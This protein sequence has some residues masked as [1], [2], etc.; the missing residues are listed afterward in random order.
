MKRFLVASLAVVAFL[1]V[2]APPASAQAPAPKVTINGLIDT[3]TTGV[4][5]GIDGNFA[6]TDDVGWWARN[7]GVFTITGEVGK[8][9]G[10]L[11]LEIDLGWGQTGS[12]ESIVSNSGQ[13]ITASSGAFGSTQNGFHQGAFDL[14]NDVG[15]VIE[16]KNLYVEFPAPIPIPTTVR[17][18]GQPF[19]VTMKP[20]VLATTDYPGVWASMELAPFAKLNLTFAQAEEQVVGMR[21]NNAFF[22]GDD[23]FTTLSLDLIPVKGITIRPFASYY[24]IQGNSHA[25]SRCRVQCAGLPSNG[26]MVAI[27]QFTGAVT[28]GA[29][30]GNYRTAST[31]E[32]WYF[33]IDAQ[34]NFGP[35]YFDPTIIYMTSN[36]DVYRGTGDATLNGGLTQGA[37]TR[38]NQD[39]NSWLIDL[40]AG[41]RAGPL[42]IEGF[43]MWT[44]GDD[45]QHD[46]FKNSR[47]YHPVNVDIAYAA[48]WTELLSLGSVDYFTSA[49]HGMGENM[50]L[51]RYGRFQVGSR[52]SYAITPAV[53]VSGKWASAWTDTKVDTDAIGSTNIQTGL[54][55]SSFGAVPCALVAPGFGN[56]CLAGTNNRGDSRYIGTE[57]SAGVTY[58]FAPG[59]TFDLVG[60]YLFTGGALDT[61]FINT[62]GTIIQ[63]DS[64]NA[65][66]V[67]ARVRYQF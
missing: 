46:S 25:F 37:G 55:T 6:R 51:G 53:T 59:L 47:V 57:F 52:V 60:A 15:G 50:G 23:F 36:V 44:P 30:L 38:V 35:V 43:G 13:T 11:A 10:V 61:T 42:L 12:N 41:F 33:G 32:R 40:R 1:G 63:Q 2:L 18:G 62:S 27:S 58:Q 49:A 39:I 66:L 14:G 17:L 67:A 31:E 26:S 45:A 8:A 22:R 21:A 28:T 56:P 29:N 19:Q 64:K 24:Q 48:G 34:T 65:Q 54:S 16:I 9:K 3:V 7:R 4:R 20:S 5:N